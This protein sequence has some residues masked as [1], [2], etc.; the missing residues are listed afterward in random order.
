MQVTSWWSGNAPEGVR[1]LPP[2]LILLLR[3]MG[4]HSEFGFFSPSLWLSGAWAVQVDSCGCEGDGGVLGRRGWRLWA[5]DGCWKVGGGSVS[6][7]GVCGFSVGSVELQ[8]CV[9]VCGRWLGCKGLRWLWVGAPEVN[10]GCSGGGE[11]L[12]V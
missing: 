4:L 8:G 10:L 1:P 11:D 5:C 3:K 12:G 2:R 7:V 6:A 9:W